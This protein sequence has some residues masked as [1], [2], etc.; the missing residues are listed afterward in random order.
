[1]NPLAE[2]ID[3]PFDGPD[4]YAPVALRDVAAFAVAT[5]FYFIFVLIWCILCIMLKSYFILIFNKR[6]ANL[7][8]SSGC[9]ESICSTM[10][11]LSD[12]TVGRSIFHTEYL[13][14]DDVRLL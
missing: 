13:P 1:M 9:T 14:D 5:F 3:M 12:V 11:S 6:A 4:S 10:T 7:V 8:K 2:Q